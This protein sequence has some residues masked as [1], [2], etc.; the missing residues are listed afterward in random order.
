MGFIHGRSNV[1]IFNGVDISA[2]TNSDEMTDDHD[3]HDVTCFG[4]V[5]KSYAAGLG[6]GQFVLGGIHDDGA[7][8]PRDIIK[9]AKAAGLPVTFVHRPEGTGSGKPQS[10]VS[11]LVKQYVETVPAADMV[12]WKSTLQMTGTLSEAN[13]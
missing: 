1:I 8:S 4:A 10:S 13:Q 3:L 2:Y 7:N 11:V 12:A 5:R 9:A 6:D